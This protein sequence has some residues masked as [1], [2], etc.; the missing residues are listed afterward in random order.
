MA[1][2]LSQATVISTVLQLLVFDPM[3]RPI[4]IDQML[5]AADVTI[6]K[7]KAVLASVDQGPTGL[8]LFR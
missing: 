5:E 4:S 1:F 6:E 3:Q 2:E 7:T 8:V